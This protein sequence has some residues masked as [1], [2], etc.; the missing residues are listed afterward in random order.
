MQYQK[1]E[2][3]FR[4]TT[5]ESELIFDGKVL[6]LYRDII[7]LPNGKQGMREYCKHNGA[8]AVVPRTREGEV[9]CVR[10]NRYA[11]GEITLEI[12]AGKF[13]F[14]SIGK[15]TVKILRRQ[16]ISAS[17]VN[18]RTQSMDISSRTLCRFS[19]IQANTVR[20]PCP[21]RAIP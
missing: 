4:E 15:N 18:T 11:V 7:N 5:A 9:V 6:H 13:D 21:A 2:S 3:Y 17:F 14:V 20:F 10:Q 8:V 12:P 19:R 16:S 1:P